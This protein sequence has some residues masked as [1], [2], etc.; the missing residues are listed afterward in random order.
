MTPRTATYYNTGL[1]SCGV[2]NTDADFIVA[3]DIKTIQSFPGAG[4]NPN[5]CASL[6]FTSLR[7]FLLANAGVHLGTRCVAG[8]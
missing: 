1:G 5:L 4:T 8:R 2:F 6:C 7:S 3:V